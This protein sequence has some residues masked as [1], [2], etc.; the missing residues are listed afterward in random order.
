MALV[1]TLP[2]YEFGI[3]GWVWDE[4]ADVLPPRCAF[5][6]N[7]FRP[8]LVFTKNVCAASHQET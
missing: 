1:N 5:E 6:K 8:V 2:T 4:L 7:N 3:G